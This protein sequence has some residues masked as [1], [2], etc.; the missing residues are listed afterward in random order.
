MNQE[1]FANMLQQ[2]LTQ[3]QNMFH[4]MFGERQERRSEGKDDGKLIAKYI[5]SDTF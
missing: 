2:F 3:Q 1:Q 5:K 4:Q